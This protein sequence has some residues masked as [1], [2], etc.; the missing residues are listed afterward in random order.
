MA[1]EAS[2]P[3]SMVAH[4]AQMDMVR[5]SVFLPISPNLPPMPAKEGGELPAPP[6]LKLSKSFNRTPSFQSGAGI[7][8]VADTWSTDLSSFAPPVSQ[9]LEFYRHSFF[10]SADYEKFSIHSRR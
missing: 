1:D 3:L 6:P 4:M 5:T 9:D 10:S 7:A 8:A 2:K